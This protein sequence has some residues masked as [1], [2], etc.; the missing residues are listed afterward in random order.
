MNLI[1]GLCRINLATMK[2]KP[3]IHSSF[4]RI[5]EQPDEQK[6]RRAFAGFEEGKITKFEFEETQNRLV[7][8]ILGIQEKIGIEIVTDGLI[9][10]YDPVSHLARNLGGFEING[11]LRFFDTNFYY[12]Q[13]V[14]QGS[15]TQSDGL[16]TDEI[17]Y[18][19][20]KSRKPVKGV[21]LGPLSLAAM[22][23]NKSSQN[24]D[25]FCIGLGSL[26]GN[27]AAKMAAAGANIVQVEE[28]WLVR[29][30]ERFDLFKAAYAKFAQA[31]GMARVLLT[32]YFGDAGRIIDRLSEI[33]ADMFGIDFA[34][35][36]GL[37]DKLAVEG[38]PKG[39][40]FGL[41]D[42]R[43]TKM[44]SAADMARQLEQMLKRMKGDEFHIT[45]SC[46][47]EFLPR[48]YAIRKL[49]LT[50]KVAGLLNG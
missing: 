30:P 43:N 18:A 40:A 38:Y 4:P 21:M 3:V 34:Y 28:P 29:N 5:G 26:L 41:I 7:D 8:D 33:P 45:T 27:L 48:S 44:E 6:L 1:F 19:V 14:A 11:L 49:E 10:W 22:S 32:F 35:S 50:S 42:G 12:R 20:G 47:L 2:I 17:K 24:L 15:V 9:R 39:I 37:A 36:P 23:L 16:L 25:D 31:K 46:G 13:P